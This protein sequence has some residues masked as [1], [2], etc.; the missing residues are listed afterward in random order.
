MVLSTTAQAL[1]SLFGVQAAVMTV[2]NGRV[3]STK[4]IGGLETQA[5]EI[6]A[7]CLSLDR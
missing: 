2:E 3:I 1:S 5:A 4:T 6:E 7:A